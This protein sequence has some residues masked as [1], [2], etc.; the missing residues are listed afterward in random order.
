MKLISDFIRPGV[1]HQT[2]ALIKA[3]NGQ[4]VLPLRATQEWGEGRGEV[5]LIRILQTPG[6]LY[7]AVQGDT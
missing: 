1:S 3:R 2:G 6:N 7:A 5:L 4:M